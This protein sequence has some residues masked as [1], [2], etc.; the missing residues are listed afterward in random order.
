MA[1]KDFANKLKTNPRK[2]TKEEPK[3]S[4]T[5]EISEIVTVKPKTGIKD[6][7]IIDTTLNNT[8][9]HMYTDKLPTKET[10]SKR[11]NLLIY[12]SIHENL[13][14]LA[15]MQAIKVNELI[16]R[17]LKEYTELEDSQKMIENHKKITKSKNKKV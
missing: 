2:T 13:E 9:T 6:T 8:D 11:L 7:P 1:N 3:N 12:P 14:R 4:L 16:N 5:D 10:K 17:V 15:E